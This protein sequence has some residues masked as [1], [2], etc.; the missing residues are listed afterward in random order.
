M[1]SKF[2]RN[3]RTKRREL[4]VASQRGEMLDK[5]RAKWLAEEGDPLLLAFS[6]ESRGSSALLHYDVEG[7]WSLRTFLAKRTMS[8]QELLGLLEA[9]QQLVDLCAQRRLPTELL[10]FDPELVFVDAQCRP[11]FAL[12]PYE[13][14]AFQQRNSPLAML[15]AMGATERLRFATPDAEGVSRRLGELLIEQ[16]GVFSAN[17]FKRFLE[18]EERQ[19]DGEPPVEEGPGTSTWASVGMAGVPETGGSTLFWSPLAGLAEEGEDEQPEPAR[20]VQ[21]EPE[22]QPEPVA[23]PVTEP[24]PQAAPE[25]QPVAQPQP[26]ATPA[27]ATP[28]TPPAPRHAW[29]CRLSTGEEYPLPLGITQRLGRG[30][31]CDI[32]LRGNPKL[33]RL[34][35]SVVWDGSEV[36]VADLGAVNGVLV[37]GRRLA[38]QQSV[39]VQIGQRFR[40]ADEELLVRVD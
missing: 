4:L 32:R 39:T 9:V 24:E 10:M 7:L 27:P 40:L 16:N 31:A 1:K 38:A 20:I 2:V 22:P 28:P 17:R 18:G 5:K 33:S 25:P 19:A 23:R 12:I 30:S 8:Q 37:D 13:E 6:Y 21:P 3:G 26:A 11:R 34:H 14:M 36:R 29:V 35:A 15:Q